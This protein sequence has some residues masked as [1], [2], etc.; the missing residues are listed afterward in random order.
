ME[1]RKS[2]ESGNK[3]LTKRRKT[4]TKAEVT[5]EL[6]EVGNSDRSALNMPGADV[7]YIPEVS[8]NVVT[9]I[10]LMFCSL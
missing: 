2:M 4:E 10:I 7:R 5:K 9:E 3:S 6:P 1:K 8:K